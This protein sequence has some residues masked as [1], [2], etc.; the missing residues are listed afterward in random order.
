M[1]AIN[2]IMIADGERERRRKT[3]SEDARRDREVAGR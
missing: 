1:L 3:I 2:A